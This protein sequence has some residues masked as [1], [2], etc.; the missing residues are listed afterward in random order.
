[1]LEEGMVCN[2]KVAY[3]RTRRPIMSD[4]EV[5]DRIEK[6]L[7][8]RAS[9]ARVWRALS[10]AR[11]FGSWFKVQLKGSFAPGAKVLGQIQVPGYEH[12]TLEMT[13]ERM[14]QERLFSYRWHPYA[15]DPK[16]DYSVEPTTLVEF[17]LE[18]KPGGTELRVVE[19]G[20]DQIPLARRAEAF[21]MNDGGWTAQIKNIER[22]VAGAQ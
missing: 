5:T 18:A 21:R 4:I 7:F 14:D 22:H 6:K 15:I 8:L 20:F 10:D 12:L 2:Q 16:V 3:Q 17:H 1:M 11:E 13:V 19:S 9:P